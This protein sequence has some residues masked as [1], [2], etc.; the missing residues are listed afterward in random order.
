LPYE[1]TAEIFPYQGNKAFNSPLTR[2]G[3]FWSVI[4]LSHLSSQQTSQSSTISNNIFR[5]NLLS[6]SARVALIHLS[7]PYNFNQPNC[8][9]TYPLPQ[10]NN[11]LP[12]QPN[13]PTGLLPP[14]V[15]RIHRPPLQHISSFSTRTHD[16]RGPPR[17]RPRG[18]RVS[19]WK[20][21]DQIRDWIELWAERQQADELVPG[22]KFCAAG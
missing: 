17:H 7:Q 14:R 2:H 16:H 8:S 22:C 15:R 13:A 6:A 3:D 19:Q 21:S 1:L 18:Q 12:P 11:V 4:C 20:P 9:T 10:R 5:Q